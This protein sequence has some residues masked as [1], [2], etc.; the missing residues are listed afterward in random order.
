M[1]RAFRLSRT[2]YPMSSESVPASLS[3]SMLKS[4]TRTIS[5]LLNSVR[6]LLSRTRS[7][8]PSKSSFVHTSGLWRSSRSTDT[9]SPQSPFSKVPNHLRCDAEQAYLGA[10]RVYIFTI[11]GQLRS[12]ENC[13]GNA[14]ILIVHAYAND[15]R[16]IL[17]QRDLT[18]A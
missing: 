14:S 9:I 15:S 16:I 10:H 6:S 7:F 12:L 8:R 11:P 18:I 4:I 13:P 1:R 5:G 3:Y 17:R 2:V